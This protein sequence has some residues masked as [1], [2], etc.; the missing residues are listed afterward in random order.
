[1]IDG[2][3][4][5][6][7]ELLVG[8]LNTTSTKDV[9]RHKKKLV[10]FVYHAGLYHDL[11]KNNIVSIVSND[12]RPLSD[13]EFNIIKLHP[14]LGLNFL[15]IDPSLGIYHDTTLGHHKWYNGM[16]GYPNSF[17]NTKSPLRIMIDI[18]TFCDCMQATT[19]RLGRNYKKEKTFD[20]LMKEFRRDAGVIYNPDLVKLVDN[21][22]T[23]KKSL[24]NLVEDGWLDIY[25][26][27]YKQFFEKKPSKKG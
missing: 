27:I 16:G 24:S 3:I 23:L 20:V 18:V 1:M 15:D 22:P 12:F 10:N 8:A 14:E 21:T 25:Y 7:P 9:K 6:K 5:Y 13:E 19:E 17:D 11:G 2:I 26:E 4:K